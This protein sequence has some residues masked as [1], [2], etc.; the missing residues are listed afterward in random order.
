MSEQERM[1]TGRLTMEAFLRAVEVHG[2][3]TREALI[4]AGYHP[5]VVLR[6]AEKAGDKGY[7]EYGVVADRPW[8]TDKGRAY[9]AA[10]KTDLADVFEPRSPM[11]D[12]CI[13]PGDVKCPHADVCPDCW[14]GDS[15]RGG[16]DG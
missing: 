1:A 8:L 13:E 3:G 15:G 16:D 11:A 12:E 5:K 4:E 14:S 6:K 9:L 7:T 10:P 2:S